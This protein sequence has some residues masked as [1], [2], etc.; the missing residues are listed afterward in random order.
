MAIVRMA[1]IDDLH[2]LNHLLNS[3]D[4]GM[5]TMPN[6]TDGMAKKIEN[7]LKSLEKKANVLGNDI[8]MFVLEE[9]EEIIGIASIYASVGID[10]PFFSYRITKVC[11]SSEETGVRNDLEILNLTNDY[12]GY[13][14][15]AT[16]FLLPEKR[17]D[18]RG[19]LLSYARLLFM[20]AHRN[21]FPENVMAEIR[22]WTDSNGCS[23]F[24]DAVGQ[25]F[26]KM[27]MQEADTL[28]GDTFKFMADLMPK[29]PIYISLLPKSAQK[30]IGKENGD[31][32]GASRL[33]QKQGFHYQ[34]MV[35]IFD[36]GACIDTRLDDTDI[37][38]HS[39][40][41]IVEVI[42]HADQGKKI[43]LANTYKKNFRAITCHAVYASDHTIQVSQHTLD[44]LNLCPGD[45]ALAYIL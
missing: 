34:G 24:W 22:G 36:A 40:K 1:N 15:L 7:S 38:R 37:A 23:P 41:V 19:K 18:G 45:Q 43:L 29:F 21:Y 33:L 27:N 9:D 11:Q 26:F 6:D 25:H 4:G 30:V 13:A 39:K 35:D 32:I 10:R 28:S 2:G 12:N 42:E 44:K 16:L 5:T 3:V 14:E 31:S 8:Y 17:K 20:T